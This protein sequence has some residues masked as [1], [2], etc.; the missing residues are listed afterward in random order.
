MRYWPELILLLPLLLVATL[1]D[2]RHRRIPNWVCVTLLVLGLATSG[3]LREGV[4]MRLAVAGALLGFFVPLIAHVCRFIGA[5]DVKLLTGVGAWLGPQSIV[6]VFVWTVILGGAV[7]LIWSVTNGST[8]A[9][10]RNTLLQG[11]Q[12]A[13]SRS[14]RSVSAVAA[15][16]TP[17]MRTTLPVALSILL[18]TALVLAVPQAAQVIPW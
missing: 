5:G 2:V 15:Q 17:S 16:Q 4:P 8:I 7:I 14:P 11:V 13:V 18:A 1:S 10:L 9:L 12:L 3:W 6:A